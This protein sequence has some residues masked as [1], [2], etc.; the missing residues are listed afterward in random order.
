MLN[1]YPNQLTWDDLPDCVAVLSPMSESIT[2]CG[3]H[4][5]GKQVASMFLLDD[6]ILALTEVMLP[7]DVEPDNNVLIAMGR[8]LVA[9]RR[10]S[11]DGRKLT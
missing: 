6:A 2:F 9:H 1:S 7:D 3:L 4:S 11:R 10:A 5:Q 8:V